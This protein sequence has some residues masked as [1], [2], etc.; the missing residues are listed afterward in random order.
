MGNW[1]IDM[2][3]E[4]AF[5]QMIVEFSEKGMWDVN[6]EGEKYR[7]RVIEQ[8]KT[9]IIDLFNRKTGARSDRLFPVGGFTMAQREVIAEKALAYAEQELPIMWKEIISPLI[10]GYWDDEEWDI[11]KMHDIDRSKINPSY[12]NYLK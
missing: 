6:K 9:L 2:H 3:G 11:I 10:G 5:N 4:D 12:L 8:D 1:Y 7:V